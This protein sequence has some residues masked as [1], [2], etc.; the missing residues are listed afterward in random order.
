MKDAADNSRDGRLTVEKVGRIPSQF[1]VFALP[2]FRRFKK[3]ESTQK[4]KMR[5]SAYKYIWVKLRF[6]INLLRD[7]FGDRY[8]VLD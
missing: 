5:Y 2:H 4:M 6:V 8:V 7:V 3:A 1:R